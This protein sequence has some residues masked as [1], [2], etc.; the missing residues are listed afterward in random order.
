MY[1]TTKGTICGL[2]L[3]SMQL[4]W[5]V[6]NPRSH[7][8]ITAMVTDRAHNWL[9]VGTSRGILTLWDLRFRIPLRSWVHPTK[10]RISRLLLC[11][12]SKEPRVIIAAG[13]HE[14]S[15]WDIEKVECRQMFAVRSG[16]EKMGGVSL[17]TFKVRLKAD[18]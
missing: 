1:A 16:D 6:E 5:S 14:V 13:K 15:L 9:L 4:S 12:H 17:D 18:L 2:D 7:G 11:A 10:S 3:R 8:I